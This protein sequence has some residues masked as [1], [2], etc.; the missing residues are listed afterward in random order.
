MATDYSSVQ[1]V[2]YS[3]NL[4][5]GQDF[6]G[7]FREFDIYATYIDEFSDLIKHLNLNEI[8]LLL[9][10]SGS[11]NRQVQLLAKHPKITSMRTQIAFIESAVLDGQSMAIVDCFLHLGVVNPAHQVKVQIKNILEWTMRVSYLKHTVKGQKREL[12]LL[13][14]RFERS[15]EQYQYSIEK[16]EGIKS[17]SEIISE[18]YKKPIRDKEGLLVALSKHFDQ[19]ENVESYSYYQLNHSGEKLISL[20]VIAKKYKKLPNLWLGKKCSMGIEKFAQEMALQVAFEEIGMESLY[21]RIE[22]GNRYPDIVCFV[23]FAEDFQSM[24]S[25]KYNWNLFEN[26]LSNVYRRILLQSYDE[27][28]DTQFIPIW[29][30]LDILD[31]SHNDEP[32]DRFININLGLL[33]DFISKNSSVKFYWKTFFNDFLIELS[34]QLKSNSQITTFGSLNVLIITNDRSI[35]EKYEMVKDF[36]EGFNLWE[37]FSNPS[38]VI[39]SY[40]KLQ[41]TIEPASSQAYLK[42]QVLTSFSNLV[43]RTHETKLNS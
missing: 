5:K 2:I 15:I 42:N 17:V 18:L 28:V 13:R 26:L 14:T 30:S 31:E 35:R 22:G 33:N 1:T 6:S 39:P 21:L 32:G 12:H 36:C 24:A 27:E 9:F 34:S 29:D 41:V 16:L 3:S 11:I 7:H 38:T 20:D 8:D 40:V 19:W 43:S 4:S 10:D 25:K 37:Y 23:N